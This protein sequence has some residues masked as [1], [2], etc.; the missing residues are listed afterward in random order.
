ME[1]SAKASKRNCP[2]LSMFARYPEEKASRVP[3][4]KKKYF[5]LSIILVIS[6]LLYNGTRRENEKKKKF[7]K[8]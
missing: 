5:L 7:F 2:R 6:V 4:E 8:F 1:G 3:N